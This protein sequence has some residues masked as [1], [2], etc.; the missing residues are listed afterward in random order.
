MVLKLPSGVLMYSIK[1]KYDH[2]LMHRRLRRCYR[3]LC[4]INRKVYSLEGYEEFFQ[5]M[6]SAYRENPQFFAR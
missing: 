5:E 4:H 6:E 1:T 2:W 3:L